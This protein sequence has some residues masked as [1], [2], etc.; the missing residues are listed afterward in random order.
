[1]EPDTNEVK[2]LMKE[3]F[4]IGLFGKVTSRKMKTYDADMVMLSH[5][6][7]PRPVAVIVPAYGKMYVTR[8]RHEKRT[9]RFVEGY[10]NRFNQSLSVERA[11]SYDYFS[12][13][14]WLY[15]EDSA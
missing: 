8:K 13:G 12:E 14:G 1:M 3:I 11:Y 4:G 2:G 6:L 7:S 10:K 9:Q 15:A 5:G